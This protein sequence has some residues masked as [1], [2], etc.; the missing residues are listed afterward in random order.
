MINDEC[1]CFVL[2]NFG[3]N[4]KTTLNGVKRGA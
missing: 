1:G 3:A 4:Y 2:I